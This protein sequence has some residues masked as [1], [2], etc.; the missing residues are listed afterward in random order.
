MKIFINRVYEDNKE[1]LG[2]LIAC[3]GI[4]KVY[5]CKTL[6]LPDKQNKRNISRIP[7]GRYK[8]VVRITE[9]RGMHLHILGVKNRSW[10]L[11]HSGNFYKDTKG[12]IIV[13]KEYSKINSDNELDVSASRQTLT[14]LMSKVYHRNSTDIEVIIS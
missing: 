8:A 11:I 10:I 3:D 14:N 12:C 2:I 5:E 13:G 6:E 9:K 7:A 1:T 4:H